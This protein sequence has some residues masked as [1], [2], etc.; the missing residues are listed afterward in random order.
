M[1]IGLGQDKLYNII[2]DFWLSQI[3]TEEELNISKG[4]M[5]WGLLGV[6]PHTSIIVLVCPDYNNWIVSKMK[7]KCFGSCEL[8]GSDL[9]ANAIVRVYCLLSE[10]VS[11]I[12]QVGEANSHLLLS[13]HL[14]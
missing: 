9:S 1:Y 3:L 6:P 10:H 14:S 4:L 5:L 11:S 13:V 2:F 8:F 7:L 12:H